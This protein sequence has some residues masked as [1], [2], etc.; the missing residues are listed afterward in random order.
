MA[1]RTDDAY[2]VAL[3]P[4]PFCGSSTVHIDGCDQVPHYWGQCDTCGANGPSAYAPDGD[5]AM[6]EALAAAL[7]NQRASPVV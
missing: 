1:P 3:Q 2:A 7:W 6:T 4:C 5:Q